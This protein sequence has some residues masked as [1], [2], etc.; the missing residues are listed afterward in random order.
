M[1]APLTFKDENYWDKLH[2]RADIG[3]MVSETIADAALRGSEADSYRL[4]RRQENGL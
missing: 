2:T 3:R 4:L 1:T